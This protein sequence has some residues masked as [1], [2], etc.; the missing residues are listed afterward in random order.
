L[1]F[2]FHSAPPVPDSPLRIGVVAPYDLSRAG[3]VATHVRAQA[4]A[5]RQMGHD[6][7]V[8]GPASAPLDAGEIALCGAF[9]VRFDGTESGIGL[10]PRAAWRVA[11]LFAADA[12]DLLH[13]HEP[14]VPVLPW[15]VLRQARVP[16]VATFHVHRETGHRWYSAARPWLHALMRRVHCRIAVS[17]PA[18]RTVARH[19]PGDYRIVPNGIDIAAFQAVRPRPAVFS[20]DR[21]SVLCVGRLEARK[22]VDH[23]IRAM[24]HVQHALPDTRLVIVGDGPERRSLVDLARS[25]SVD[26]AFAGRVSDE[27]LPGYT[28]SADVICAPALGGESFG[29]VLLEAMACG[30][31][32]VASRIEAYEMLVWAADCGILVPP[33][34][35]A[36]LAEA[37]LKLLADRALREILGARG[38]CAVRQYDWSSIA[39]VL[40]GIY[41]DSLT[42]EFSK[43]CDIDAVESAG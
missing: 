36:S 39:R 41:R 5:L 26:A 25:L 42:V 24:A 17:D 21:H 20:S 27:E 7:G 37:I 40:D 35:A 12:F 1:A 30:K 14:L 38:A 3:G 32:I 29:V 16:V 18:R 11:R 2:V 15:L 8:Y 23:L 34:D 6:V 33:G 31:P 43:R 10:D 9:T 22:G 13:V 19:F 28:Q 4:R